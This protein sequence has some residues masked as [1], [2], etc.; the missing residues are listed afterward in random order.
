MGSY[1]IFISYSHEDRGLVETVVGI[2]EEN[3]LRPMWDAGFTWGLGFHEQI[4]DFI[5]H[6]HVFIPI[7]TKTS[8]NRG[9]VHQE[10]GYALALNIP[11]LPLTVGEVPPGQMLQHLQSISWDGND[12]KG[13]KIQLT[14]ATFD[15]LV[16][17][18]GRN[19]RALFECAEHHEERT[20]MIIEYA[21]KVRN[22]NAYGHVR[23]KGA[24]SSFQIPD[25]PCFHPAWKERYN[26]EPNRYHCQQLRRERKVLEEHAREKGCSLIIDPYV[27]YRNYGV[28]ARRARLETLLEFLES[29]D[30]EKIRVA[31]HKDMPKGQNLTI[32]GDW[33]AAEA[34]SVAVGGGYQQTI[35]TR[36]APTI[37]EQIKIF[38]EELEFV[39]KSNGIDV[40]SSRDEAIAC[41]KKILEGIPK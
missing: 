2:L 15:S 1:R 12:I 11:I 13:L 9:W 39:L 32:V 34:V 21:T 10:I 4:K 27:D 24:L 31:I 8:S 38:D 18:I 29:I 14:K 35:F 40:D 7:I 17:I 26:Y 25:K 5:A 3:G 36:H 19:S 30:A 6:A 37:R 41:I 16:K 23:L 20:S 33:F 22:M 28:S